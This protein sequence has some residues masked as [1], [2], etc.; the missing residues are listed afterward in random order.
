LRAVLDPNVFISAALSPTGAPARVLQAWIDGAFELLVSPLLLAELERALAYPKLRKRI[1]PEDAARMV[2]WLRRSATVA[3]DP[4]GPPPLTSRDPGD[5]YLLAFAAS[6]RAALV[7]G[8]SDLLSLGGDLPI[9]SPADFLRAVG[10][11]Q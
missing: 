6:Q 1:P 5:D 8:D 4:D 2:D 3:G 7:S 10:P 9:Y 11:T